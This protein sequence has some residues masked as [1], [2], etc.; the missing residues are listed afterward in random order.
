MKK[1]MFLLMVIAFIMIPVVSFAECYGIKLKWDA[2][3][4]S[5]LEGYR[6]FMRSDGNAYDYNNPA[7]EVDRSTVEIWIKNIEEGCYAFVVRAFDTSGKES[8][9]SNEVGPDCME[10]LFII[11]TEAPANPSGCFINN[12]VKEP[13]L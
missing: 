6:V 7:A 9:D 2:N 12:I 4:E 3:T 13:C 1:T 11:I 10:D 5:D 8:G